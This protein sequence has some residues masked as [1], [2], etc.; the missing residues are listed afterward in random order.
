[1]AGDGEFD[2]KV[3]LP[4]EAMTK[5]EFTRWLTELDSQVNEKGKV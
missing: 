4:V 1:M 5:S 2:S 3:Q